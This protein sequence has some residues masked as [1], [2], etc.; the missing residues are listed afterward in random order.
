MRR[1]SAGVSAFES[2]D[3]VGGMMAVFFA[4]V[5]VVGALQDGTAEHALD[6]ERV[7]ALAD[8]S[9]CGLVAGIDFVGGFLEELADDLGRGFENGGAQQLLKVGDEGAAGLGGTEGGNQLLDFLL[10]GEVEVSG[11]R[12]FFLMPALR[13]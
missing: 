4:G 10:P 13:S 9:R 3:F 1:A 12:R 6:L 8:F 11:V 7:A 5:V 2:E